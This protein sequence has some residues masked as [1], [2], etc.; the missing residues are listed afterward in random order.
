MA[1]VRVLDRVG[2]VAPMCGCNHNKQV[3]VLEARQRVGGRLYS[4]R[5]GLGVPL[6]LSPSARQGIACHPHGVVRALAT[7]MQLHLR[8]VGR[9]RDV[10]GN[11]SN[12]HSSC[13]PA[14]P[15]TTI[16]ML[17]GGVP[18]FDTDGAVVPH[19]VRECM[20]V[21]VPAMLA[22]ATRLFRA[23]GLRAFNEFTKV[24]VEPSWWRWSAGANAMN[25]QF[26]RLFVRCCHRAN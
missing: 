4:E 14:K 15:T 23:D 10:N 12:S 11:S 8:P 19:V 22:F 24:G 3:T 9:R 5:N 1:R 18:L 2:V 16:A 26:V 25:K 13:S 6:E 20:D 21:A 7:Q 17:G